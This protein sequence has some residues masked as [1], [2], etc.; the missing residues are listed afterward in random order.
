[1]PPPTGSRVVHVHN[2]GA[3]SWNGQTDFWNYVNQSTVDTMVDQGMMALTGAA[4]V[5]QAWESLLPNYTAGQF[6]AIKLN[7]N[8][9]SA[10]N[11]ADG[12]IDALIQPVN[13]VVR[14][15]KLIGVPEANIWVY[16]ASRRIP[17]RFVNGNL[18]SGVVFRDAGCRQGVS[19]SSTDPNAQVTFRPPAGHPAPP[20]TRIDDVLINCSYL[21]NMPILK[22]HRIAGITLAFKNHFGDI[23][24]PWSLHNYIRLTDPL[25]RSDYSLLVDI[26]R[27]PH[28]AGKTI[29]VLGDGL[30]ASKQY[31]GPP[32]VWSTFGN[33]TPNSLFFATDPVAGDC[34]MADLLTAEMTIP[35]AAGDYLALAA[36][37][38]LGTYE[39][40]DP[41]GAGYSIIDYV[42]I[43]GSR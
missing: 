18:Y 17:N 32:S 12:Q 24:S 31:D 34:V 10:C 15:L 40:G 14:G 43:S 16:D 7:F 3:T 39:R 30:V 38:G 37:A 33:Q 21:I 28:I 13:A 35:A 5:A 4:T 20:A 2:S 25:Y 19:W 23:T 6:V 27:N 1:M 41:W 9:C 22:P 26:F 8:N 11:D 42:K 36:Q 29:L